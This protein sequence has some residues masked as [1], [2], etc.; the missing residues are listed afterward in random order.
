[1]PLYVDKFGN[2][3]L[4]EAIK[5]GHDVVASLL[6]KEGASLKFDAAGDFLCTAV[7]KG[8]SEFVKRVLGF[9]VDPNSK[10]YDHRTPLHVAAAE[11][12]FL[13]SKFLVE[14]GASVFPKDRYY[15]SVVSFYYLTLV[16]SILLL[17]MLIVP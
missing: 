10:N 1:M 6:V 8:D 4:L 16:K 13:M 15:N 3:P 5:N 7:S 2:T 12:L 17:D 9:G 11:G 14:A